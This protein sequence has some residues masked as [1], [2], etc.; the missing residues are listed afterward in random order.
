MNSKRF[1]TGTALMVLVLITPA[2][3]AVTPDFDRDQSD[4]GKML[5][6]LGRGVLNV[7]TSPVEIPRNIAIEWDRT[8]PVTGII[9]G[10]V[11]GI[12]WGFARFAT[13]VYEA[14]TFPLP[15]P[16][17][18]EAMMRPEFVITDIWGATIPGLT[19]INEIDPVSGDTTRVYPNQFR[20]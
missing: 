3:A 8:D 1:L 12:A 2:M 18:Y 13:G 6:K 4:I 16:P 9:M 5:H 7:F 10:G 15:V 20:F 19:D 17:N 14:F 11:K